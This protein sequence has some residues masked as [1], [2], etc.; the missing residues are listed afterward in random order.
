MITSV[1]LSN[2]PDKKPN[3]YHCHDAARAI[4][5]KILD[6]TGKGQRKL[7]S[8]KGASGIKAMLGIKFKNKKLDHY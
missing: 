5:E 3:H 2:F 4:H 6:K 8:R 1:Y 7:S